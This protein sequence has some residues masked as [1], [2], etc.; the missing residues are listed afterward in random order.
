MQQFAQRWHRLK[1]QLPIFVGQKTHLSIASSLIPY[2]CFQSNARI[3]K[4]ETIACKKCEI[5][6]STIGYRW[7]PFS[8]LP[9]SFT[10]KS[11]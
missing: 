3:E 4:R 1:S 6:T 7:L 10:P 5:A 9:H 11:N 2:F 8:H